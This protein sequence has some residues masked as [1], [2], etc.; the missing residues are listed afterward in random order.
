[1][2]S[3]SSLTSAGVRT[4]LYVPT[5]STERL[6]RARSFSITT[7][8][9]EGFF[10]APNRARRIINIPSPLK[11]YETI[12]AR[13]S[14]MGEWLRLQHRQLQLSQ[15]LA[16]HADVAG[17]AFHHFARLRILLEQRVDVLHAGAAAFGDTPPPRAVNDHVII[18]LGRGH[19]IDDGHDAGDLFFVHLDVLEVFERTELRHH[20]QQVLQ[21]AQLANLLDLIAK[22]AERELVV[23][24]LALHLLGGFLIDAL[25]HLVDEREHVAHAQNA[26]GHAI[27]EERLQRVHLLADT[28][29]LQRLVGDGADRQSR[30]A[31]RVAVHFRENDAG[32]AEPFVKLVGG[33]HRVLTGHG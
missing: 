2:R 3:W 4:G 23:D 10:L 16:H 33:F 14:A 6:F 29:E 26:R 27:R 20:A 19:R 17:K 9:Y 22:I 13:P 15:P 28:D 18:P 5:T 7:T 30:A 8:R 21:R 31:A 11:F 24:E 12:P 32:D 1:M 25:L